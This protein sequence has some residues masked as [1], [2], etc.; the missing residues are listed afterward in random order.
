MILK[1]PAIQAILSEA[2]NSPIRSLHADPIG[3]GSI[4]ETYRLT[5]NGTLKLFCKINSS[6]GFP[7]L[8]EKEKRGLELLASLGII[9]V[10][11]VL[12]TWS[13][14]EKQVLILEWINQGPKTEKFWNRFG[15]KMA[16]L[17][18][19]T[20]DHFGWEE[21]NYLGA[22]VQSNEASPNWI[23]FFILQRLEPQIRLAADKNLLSE[24][25]LAGFK[26]LSRFLPDIFP[27]QAPSLLHGD[28]WSGN[29]LC[30]QESEPVLFDPAVYFG[31]PGMDFGMTT[32]FGGFEKPFYEAY[33]HLCPFPVN[34]L[35]HWETCRLYPL[36]VHLN[37]FGKSYLPEIAHT[38]RRF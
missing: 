20:D 7:A 21:D 15:E 37:L 3:G 16:A 32:L 4:N 17:H 13:I 10:P 18:H 19:I 33:G 6:N 11:K 30:D 38:L 1:E 23:D 26:R 31:H 25:D 28:L 34:Y 35:D 5:V 14:G 29:F 2:I 12:A 8:F 9:R 36:L 27:P 24:A 22:L